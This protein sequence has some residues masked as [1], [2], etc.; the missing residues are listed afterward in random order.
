M[1]ISSPAKGPARKMVNPAARSD[2][3]MRTGGAEILPVS[4]ASPEGRSQNGLVKP[5]EISPSL[6]DRGVDER[7]LLPKTRWI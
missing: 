6:N 7:R 3:T 1:S 5:D 4:D 2:K